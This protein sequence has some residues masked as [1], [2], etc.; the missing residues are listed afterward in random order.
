VLKRFYFVAVVDG[1]FCLRTGV[2][3]RP[4]PRFGRHA[5]LEW[6]YRQL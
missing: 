3:H 5:W 1:E 2:V 6:D 4:E